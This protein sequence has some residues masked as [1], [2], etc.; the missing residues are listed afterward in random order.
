MSGA[1]ELSLPMPPHRMGAWRDRGA[2]RGMNPDMFFPER[3]DDARDAKAVCARCPV[4]A[5][6]L[7]WA[8]TAPE[9]DGIWGGTSGKDRKKM[10][11][12][13]LCARCREVRVGVNGSYCEDCRRAVRRVQNATATAGY[14]ARKRAS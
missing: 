7:E 5:D 2:C 1:N 9:K 3:G 13:P 12:T 4:T 11:F 10:R 6:C 8:L 14:K